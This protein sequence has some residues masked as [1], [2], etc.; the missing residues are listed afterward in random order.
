MNLDTTNILIGTIIS[1]ITFFGGAWISAYNLG[2]KAKSYEDKIE[3]A[4][5]EID[6]HTID[7]KKLQEKYDDTKELFNKLDKNMGIEFAKIGEQ[8]KNLTG[9]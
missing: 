2:K 4:Q 7:I 1:L 3:D 8:I 5:L 9:K 6:S